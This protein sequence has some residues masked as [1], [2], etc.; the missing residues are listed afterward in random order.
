[1]YGSQL[2]SLM[3]TKKTRH[4]AHTYDPVLDYPL[5]LRKI[6][7]ASSELATDS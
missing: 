2:I 4:D 1:M 7:H 5:V 3:I 6:R